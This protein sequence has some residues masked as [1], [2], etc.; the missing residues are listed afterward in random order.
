M[1]GVAASGCAAA[2]KQRIHTQGTAH[3]RGDT[4]PTGAKRKPNGTVVYST[5]P[6][7]PPPPPP[8]SLSPLK[9][10]SGRRE[11]ERGGPAAGKTAHAMGINRENNDEPTNKNKTTSHNRRNWRHRRHSQRLQHTQRPLPFPPDGQQTNKATKST[12]RDGALCSRAK[13]KR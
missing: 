13:G 4:A 10:P 12:R 1:G 6:S 3:P 8:P 7:L 9:S 5:A 2:N 11:R